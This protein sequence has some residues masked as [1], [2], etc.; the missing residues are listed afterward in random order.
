MAQG[1]RNPTN[2]WNPESKCHWQRLSVIQYLESKNVVDFLIRGDKRHTNDSLL[3]FFPVRKDIYPPCLFP[4]SSLSSLVNSYCQHLVKQSRNK[5]ATFE[6]WIN[7][8][9]SGADPHRFPPFY[10]NRSEF[11]QI[12]KFFMKKK[13]FQVKIWPISWL[14]DSGGFREWKKNNSPECMPRTPL[15]AYAFDARFGKRSVFIL[16]PRL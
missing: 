16:D 2:E 7:P 10:E 11:S 8:A 1:I 15:E 12:N 6:N 9:N 5:R 3:N 13:T 4:D 14:N